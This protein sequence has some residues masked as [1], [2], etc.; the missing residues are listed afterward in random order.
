MESSFFFKGQ[1]CDTELTDGES[2]LADI[3]LYV[4]YRLELTKIIATCKE[5]G[6]ML[7]RLERERSQHR[8]N[9]IFGY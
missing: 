6:N 5:D 8:K 7:V 9:E 3:D 2:Q 4:K 1:L